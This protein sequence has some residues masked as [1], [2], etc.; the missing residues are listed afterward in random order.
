[1]KTK[2]TT[3]QLGWIPFY[4]RDVAWDS[5]DKIFVVSIPELPGCMTHGN[6]RDAANHHADQAIRVHLEG[7]AAV[8]EEI[9]RPLALEEPT[10]DMIVRGDASLRRLLDRE[11][12]TFGFSSLNKLM[13][14]KLAMPYRLPVDRDGPALKKAAKRKEW[15]KTGFKKATKVQRS[16]ATKKA[17]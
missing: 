8:G 1:M 10:A 4:N 6:D 11:K 16:L 15:A 14:A 13:V 2:L 5:E 12:V 9:P 17:K 7:M 3:E